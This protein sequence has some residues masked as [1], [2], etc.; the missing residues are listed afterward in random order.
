M[1]YLKLDKVETGMSLK[2]LILESPAL[3]TS[4]Y[5]E[6]GARLR[7]VQVEHAQCGV[8]LEEL[9]QSHGAE[10]GSVETVAQAAAGSADSA[11]SSALHMVS[12]L[13]STISYRTTALI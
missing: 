10:L 11:R 12:T 6:L 7:E 13:H 2:P 4:R 1:R 3:R 8:T 5:E 9:R